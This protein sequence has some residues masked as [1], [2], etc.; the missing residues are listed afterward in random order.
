MTTVAAN[1]E[2]P[3]TRQVRVRCHELAPRI[4]NLAANVQL[5]EDAILEAAATGVQL[6]VL[7]ELA[8]SGY[9]LRDGEEARRSALPA[10]NPYFDRWAGLL[11]PDMT[12]VLGFCED[13]NGALFNSAVVLAKTGVLAVYRKTHLWDEEQSIFALGTEAPPVV[14][15]P[16]GPLGVLI[17]YDLEFPELPRLLALAGAEIIAVPTNWPVVP[18]PEHE[19]PPEVI[20]AMAAARSSRVAIAC[21]DRSGDE[22]G[23]A[24]TQG[25]SIV[26]TDGWLTG[27]NAAGRA[28]AVIEVLVGRTRIGMANDV[29]EDRRPELYGVPGVPGVPGGE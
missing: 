8:T 17:C 19:H 24:W 22:R 13:L 1:G 4:G 11:S 12:V 16:V 29:L 27:S 2:I 18:R 7:P 15:T 28:D 5:I 20:Q 26:G 9:Y 23:H 25:T 6:L 21:C 3:A 10:V 14:R